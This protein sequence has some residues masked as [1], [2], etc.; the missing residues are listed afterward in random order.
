[1]EST[2]GPLPRMMVDV[3]DTVDQKWSLPNLPKVPKVS[4]FS[5]YHSIKRVIF[6]RNL[7][8]YSWNPGSVFSQHAIV[9]IIT[10]IKPA[11]G[12][13]CCTSSKNFERTFSLGAWIW[14]FK[15]CFYLIKSDWSLIDCII[16]QWFLF[17]LC[18][19]ICTK[20]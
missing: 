13:T 14:N 10:Q 18:T 1:M 15:I 12:Y 19:S 16:K 2:E 4:I 7:F 3:Q 20:S 11:W 8:K 6:N 17:L 9:Y 5:S